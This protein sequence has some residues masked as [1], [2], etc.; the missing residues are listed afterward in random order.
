MQNKV[1]IPKNL[2]ITIDI[3]SFYSNSFNNRFFG[4]KMNV[5]VFISFG[6]KCMKTR[7]K[8]EKMI[9]DCF[10]ALKSINTIR[11]GR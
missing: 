3:I 4:V 6:A 8:E 9:D 10:D 11:M 2:A 1:E 5:V 7:P